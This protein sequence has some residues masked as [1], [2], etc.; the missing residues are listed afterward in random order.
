MLKLKR[1]MEVVKVNMK[2]VG[3]REKDAKD[4]AK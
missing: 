1:F 4:R 3:V 2:V